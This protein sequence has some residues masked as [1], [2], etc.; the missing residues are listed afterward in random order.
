MIFP[1]TDSDSEES[2]EQG[3]PVSLSTLGSQ[4]SLSDFTLEQ[5]E[6]LKHKKDMWEQGIDM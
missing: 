3:S 6:S 5:L 4:T 2:D 1:P